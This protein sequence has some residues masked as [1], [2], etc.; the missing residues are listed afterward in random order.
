MNTPQEPA[1]D[2]A[3][4]DD[5]SGAAAAGAAAPDPVQLQR[6]W[7]LVDKLDACFYVKDLEGRYLF[8]NQALGAVFGT[9]PARIVGQRDDSFVDLAASGIGATDTQALSTGEKVATDEVVCMMDGTCRTFRSV[10][11]PLFD[12]ERRVVGLCGISTD[13]TEQRRAVDELIERNALLN[14]ILANVDAAIYLKD[15]QGRYLYANRPVLALYDRELGDLIGRT[16][17][18]LMPPESAALVAEYDADVFA[19][20]GGA[21]REE[22]IVGADGNKHHFRSRKVKLQLPGQPTCLIGFSTEIT[23]LRGLRTRLEQERITDSLTGL[24]N[25]VMFESALEE[26]LVMATLGGARLAVVIIDLDQFKYI[27]NNFGQAVGDQLIQLVGQRLQQSNVVLGSLARLSG[28]EF[29]FTLP[30]AE[31][32]EEVAHQVEQIRAFLAQP[33]PVLRQP[34]HL[35]FSAG[36]ALSRGSLHGAAE[37]LGRAEAAMY[38]AKDNGRDQYRFYSPELGSTVARR[39]E[40][41]R[42][43]RAA[44]GTTVGTAEFALHYQPKMR[45]DGSIA[46][47]EALIRWNRPGVGLVAPDNFIPLAEQLGLL[48]HL[49]RWV[50]EQACRQIAAWRDAGLGT[51]PVAVNLSTSQLTSAALPDYVFDLMR[52]HRIEPGCL[53]MELTESM[54]MSDPDL[55]IA[56][57]HRLRSGGV[58]LSIDDFGTGFSSMSYL[59]QLPVNY[60]KLDRSFVQNCAVDPKDADLCAG[61]MALAHKLDMHVVAEGVETAEQHRTLADCDC[62]L[63]QG[64]L[65]SR[66]MPAGAATEFLRGMH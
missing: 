17:R 50:I 66:P 56:I 15:A 37:L 43:L 46:G 2:G 34:L 18:E 24:A 58:A 23:E 53:E 21:V 63:F 8:A 5:A 54:M 42:D 57:L 64:F 38:S 29:A 1:A 27:N 3:A 33:Y 28:D 40:L 47:F 65:F 20:E 12:A 9:D 32:I 39:V 14:T 13:I 22:T 25:R 62:D 35:T 10:K 55:A 31:T 41:E 11:L 16:D 59:R 36:V 45:R 60:L 6:L 48:L 49:G 52:E 51:I 19:G 30:L 61:I 4:P 26:Q 7:T 44:V